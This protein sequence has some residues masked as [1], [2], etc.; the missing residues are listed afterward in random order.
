MDIRKISEEEKRAYID[1]V[2]E[3]FTD[4]RATL[5]ILSNDMESGKLLTQASSVWIGGQLCNWWSD[6]IT[7]IRKIEKET[8]SRTDLENELKEAVNDNTTI[9]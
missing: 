6:F 3:T 9:N 4:I 5:K 1:K 7:Q 8:K 2:N